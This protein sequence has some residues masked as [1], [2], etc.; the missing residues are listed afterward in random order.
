MKASSSIQTKKKPSRDIFK[1]VKMRER[2]LQAI[3]ERDMSRLHGEL[4]VWSAYGLYPS[5]YPV[6]RKIYDGLRQRR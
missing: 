5:H 1:G 4:Q 2:L 3:K 6:L